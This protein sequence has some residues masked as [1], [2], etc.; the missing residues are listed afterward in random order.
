MR[1]KLTLLS[2][3]TLRVAMTTSNTMVRYSANIES[4][5]KRKDKF[6]FRKLQKK[7][8]KNEL[9]EFF[10]SKLYSEWRQLDW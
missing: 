4:F 9:V 6:F 2:S 3:N 7:Y 8:D 1:I 5:L 10:V